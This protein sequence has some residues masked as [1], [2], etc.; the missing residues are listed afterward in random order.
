VFCLIFLR[1]YGQAMQQIGNMLCVVVI[2]ALDAP[3][4]SLHAAVTLAVEFLCG[5]VWA[6][7]LTLLVWRIRPFAPARAAL[8]RLARRLADLTDDLDHLAQNAESQAD[9]DAHAR[10]HRSAVREAIEQARAVALDTIRQRGNASA[11]ANRLAVRLASFE[12]LFSLLIAASET[13]AEDGAARVAARRPLRLLAQ[14]LAGLGPEIEA[15]H[16]LDTAPRRAAFGRLQAEIAK[17]D[18]ASVIRHLLD[19]AAERLAVLVTVSAPAGE[20]IETGAAGGQ[21]RLARLG[22]TLGERLVEPIRANL[23]WQSVPLRHTLRVAIVIAPVFA[24]TL[25]V[26]SPFAHWLTITLIFTMQPYFSAAWVRALER[27]GGTVLGGVIAALI[28]FVCHSKPAIALAM[29]PLTIIAFSIRGVSFGAFIAVLTPVVVL[30]VEQ[31]S[32]GANQIAVAAAR[33]GF[34]VAGGLL[35]VLA[36]LFL[37]PGFEH[38]RLDAARQDA[39]AAHLAWL[40]LVFDVLIEPGKVAEP[41]LEAARRRAG[42]ASNNLEAS[43]SRALLEPHRRRDPALGSAIIANAA[44][45]RIAGRLSVLAL[46]RPAVPEAAR[47]S[48]RA[49]R[50]WLGAA[51]ATSRAAAPRPE[52]PNMAPDV[53]NALSRLARQ[54]ELIVYGENRDPMD[55][56]K[57]A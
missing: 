57:P 32:P 20:P 21:A 43:I 35:S 30:L 9:F 29:I 4:P 10:E 38:N 12:H 15:D 47:S 6:M 13:I 27:I 49:W 46:D 54:A 8:G 18:P 44:L 19:A 11:R 41:A 45:R 23:F 14:W 34:T 52:L 37:F 55:G 5:T 26:N 16:S 40:H 53:V 56:T 24:F 33:V 31:L 1:V 25:D 17:L 48:W 7:V 36:N 50:D 2:L 3:L 42:L 22:Q 39:I 28:S 51:L